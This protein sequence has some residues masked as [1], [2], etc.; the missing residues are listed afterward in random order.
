VESG[1]VPTFITI[2]PAGTP[3]NAA[4]TITADLNAM[5]AA[6]YDAIEGNVIVSHV[7][8][9]GV[10]IAART[11]TLTKF[12]NNESVVIIDNSGLF[13]TLCDAGLFRFGGIGFNNIDLTA[14][15][16]GIVPVASN[17]N[18]IA[19]F[20]GLGITIYIVSGACPEIKIINYAPA[21]TNIPA[22]A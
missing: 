1:A 12:E 8:T 20:L 18:I 6:G 2:L 11:E 16:G 14:Y 19:A 4:C 17:A 21:A 13:L 7:Y 3:D 15:G 10:M 9:D 5:T 22:T